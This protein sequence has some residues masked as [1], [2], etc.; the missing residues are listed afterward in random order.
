MFR[1]TVDVPACWARRS[2]ARRLQSR[3]DAHREKKITSSPATTAPAVALG[4]TKRKT[5]YA[6][7]RWQKYRIEQT[8][9]FLNRLAERDYAKPDVLITAKRLLQHAMAGVIRTAKIQG[10]WTLELDNMGSPLLWAILLCKEANVREGGAF[11]HWKVNSQ[12]AQMVWRTEYMK[13][14]INDSKEL[15]PHQVERG[16]ANRET[17]GG[18]SLS[19][20]PQRTTD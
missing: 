13:I 5:N 9:I 19:R 20:A 10:G 3:R 11:P 6:S 2:V 15:R 18:P 4:T 16:D 14:E 7:E 1:A 17:L 12:T 8:E